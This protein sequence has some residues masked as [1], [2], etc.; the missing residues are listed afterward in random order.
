MFLLSGRRHEA[1]GWRRTVVAWNGSQV[2][3]KYA[4]KRRKHANLCYPRE[5]TGAK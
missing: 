5:N 3:H 4:K 1:S 2:G